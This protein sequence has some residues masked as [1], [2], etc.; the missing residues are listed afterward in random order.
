[1]KSFTLQHGQAWSELYSKLMG[2]LPIDAVFNMTTPHRT[3]L[4]LRV[5]GAPFGITISL[6]RNGTWSATYYPHEFP[7]HLKS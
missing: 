2:D 5:D 6:D 4:T 7:E 3:V 1:M